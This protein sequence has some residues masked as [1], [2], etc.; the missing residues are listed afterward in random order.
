MATKRKTAPQYEEPYK[1]PKPQFFFFIG[2]KYYY[3]LTPIPYAY[4][5]HDFKALKKLLD[6][7][8]Q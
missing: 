8:K 3:R 4:K 1:R 5:P 6:E 2:A 7:L